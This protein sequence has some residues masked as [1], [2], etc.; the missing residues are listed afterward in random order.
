MERYQ[1]SIW[2]YSGKVL[3]QN[4]DIQHMNSPLDYFLKPFPNDQIEICLIE[5]NKQLREQRKREANVTELYKLFSIITLI[6][7][8]ETT[9]R[10]WLGLTVSQNKYI[11]AIKLGAMTVLYAIPTPGG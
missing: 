8:F 1:W 5:T 10:A 4:I 7:R 6:T 11:P 2:L 9:S 3:Y